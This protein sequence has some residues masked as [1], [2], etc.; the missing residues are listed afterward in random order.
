MLNKCINYV[1]FIILIIYI[2][3]YL[4]NLLY[5]KSYALTKYIAMDGREKILAFMGFRVFNN[6]QLLQELYAL[7]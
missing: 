3:I 7:N 1:N 5:S 6:I 2:Y 4:E